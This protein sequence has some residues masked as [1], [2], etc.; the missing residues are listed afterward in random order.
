MKD[1]YSNK[2]TH[3]RRVVVD[4]I[5]ALIRTPSS[6]SKTWNA[7]KCILYMFIFHNVSRYNFKILNSFIQK[8]YAI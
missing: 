7:R 8:S 3:N 5:S 4:Q 6:T 1:E 2:K